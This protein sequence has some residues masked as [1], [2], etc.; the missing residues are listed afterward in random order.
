MLLKDY[1]KGLVDLL[2]DNPNY[3]FAPS[4]NQVALSQISQWV[5][6]SRIRKFEPMVL[7]IQVISLVVFGIS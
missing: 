4:R 2:K 5:W 1:V 3:G 6:R 7:G